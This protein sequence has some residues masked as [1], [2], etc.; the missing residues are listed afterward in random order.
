[1]KI[2]DKEFDN[3]LKNIKSALLNNLDKKTNYKDI[4]ALKYLKWCCDRFLLDSIDFDHSKLKLNGI[5][6][7]DFGTNMGSEL[8]KLRPA[9]LWRSS[10]DKKMWTVI[11]LSTKCFSDKYYFHYD[12]DCLPFGTAKIE[13]L[14][15]FSYKRIR[16]PYFYNKK[17]AYL[18][19]KDRENI[20]KAISKYYLFLDIKKSFFK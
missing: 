6:W 13:S 20:L 15:N 16:E 12:I 17:I 9:I 14:A 4:E 19:K 2:T 3:I 18:T 1:M 8:R 7:V 11:P 5:Y 10:S